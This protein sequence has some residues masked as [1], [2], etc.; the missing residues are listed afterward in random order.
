MIDPGFGATLVVGML[1]F[2]GGFLAATLRMSGGRRAVAVMAMLAGAV[3]CLMAM[4]RHRVLDDA[5]LG[6]ALVVVVG[7][8]LLLSA[9]CGDQDGGQP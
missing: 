5:G 8:L 9:P 2:S 4:V 6:L 3:V 7:G 1:L